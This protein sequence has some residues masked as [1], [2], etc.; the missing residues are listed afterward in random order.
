ML[1]DCLQ[2]GGRFYAYERF[3]RIRKKCSGCAT[4]A[5]RS[6]RSAL[7]NEKNGNHSTLQLA[8]FTP[9]AYKKGWR[10]LYVPS[11]LGSFFIALFFEFRYTDDE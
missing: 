8:V 5:Q 11:G 6:F 1:C 10:E 4:I 2:V 7:T 9:N 3:V